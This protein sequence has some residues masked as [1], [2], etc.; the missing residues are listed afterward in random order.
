MVVHDAEDRVDI[1]FGKAVLFLGGQNKAVKLLQQAV[2]L[3][4]EQQP[5]VVLVISSHSFPAGS[6]RC[7]S[8]GQPVTKI[9]IS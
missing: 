9:T 4:F 6:A 5:S 7:S 3:V 1:L 8:R 2:L